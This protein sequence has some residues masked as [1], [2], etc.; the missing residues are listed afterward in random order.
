MKN[1]CP[2]KKPHPPRCLCR[3]LSDWVRGVVSPSLLFMYSMGAR[4]DIAVSQYFEACRIY[5]YSVLQWKIQK[6]ICTKAEYREFRL[7]RRRMYD[8][9]RKAD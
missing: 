7:K 6:R 3:T 9:Q 1:R 2:F 5:R 8:E 4:T